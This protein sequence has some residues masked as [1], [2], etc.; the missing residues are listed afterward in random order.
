MI[1]KTRQRQAVLQALQKAGRPL[2][3]PEIHELG[4]EHAPRLGLRT[5]YRIV[6]E[7]VV[8]RSLV[9]VDFPGQPLRYDLTRGG[10]HSPHLICRGCQQVFPVPV[11]TP[12][13]PYPT[14]DGFQI[15]GHEVILYGLC[16]ACLSAQQNTASQPVLS[17]SS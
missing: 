13:I 12:D 1:R 17:Q 7:M 14:K 16:P 3:I 4:R 11:E 15:D 2:S 8:D 5:V 9:G 6:H 10:Q